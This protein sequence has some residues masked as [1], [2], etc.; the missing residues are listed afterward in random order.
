[1]GNNLPKRAVLIGAGMV[2]HTHVAA[3]ADARKVTIHG[4]QSRNPKRAR[5][6]AASAEA[7]I[8]ERVQVYDSIDA[9]A[10]DPA[11]DFVIVKPEVD[12]IP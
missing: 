2:A 1:M 10:A 9:V 5:D 6:L 7:L 4:V 11:V 3:C 8:G 12:A